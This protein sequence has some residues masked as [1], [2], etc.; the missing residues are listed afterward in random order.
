M[1]LKAALFVAMVMVVTAAPKDDL[2]GDP[3]KTIEFDRQQRQIADTNRDN[4]QGITKPAIRRQARR[5]GLNRMFHNYGMPFWNVG[6]LVWV[7]KRALQ[8]A[9]NA[10][11]I[12]VR[13]SDI[14]QAIIEKGRPDKF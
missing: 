1:I 9:E 6:Y 11:S 14:T 7:I 12:T 4:I 8:I 10:G 3:S 5:G 2:R 13:H